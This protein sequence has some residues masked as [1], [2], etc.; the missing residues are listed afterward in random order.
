MRYSDNT[1][2]KN[3]RLY[4]SSQFM[5]QIFKDIYQLTPL[6]TEKSILSSFYRY[7]IK[8]DRA[9]YQQQKGISYRLIR[10]NIIAMTYTI[11]G[12]FEQWMTFSP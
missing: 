4:P 7:F 2:K 3:P 11:I 1:F 12:H 10:R 5:C 9:M 8:L 6:V